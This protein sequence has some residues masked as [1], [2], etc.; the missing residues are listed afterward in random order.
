[1]YP[2]ATAP[3]L[4]ADIPAVRMQPPLSRG[5]STHRGLLILAGVGAIVVTGFLA[6][7][8]IASASL[9]VLFAG[10]KYLSREPGPPIIA[11]AFSYQW[12][13][14]TVGIFYFALTGRRV[15]EMQTDDYR[16]MVWIGLASV[17]VLFTGFYIA[18]RF[19]RIRR[20]RHS[21][22]IL[23]PWTTYR[24]AVTYGITVAI[25]GA[26]QE[27][28]WTMSGLTQVILVFSRVRYVFLFFLITRLSKPRVRI[29]LITAIVL[30][31]VVLG[32]T[33]F[34]ADFREPLVII[35]VAMFGTMDR[36]KA[37]SWLIVGS[38]AL[39]ALGSALIWT[40]VKSIVRQ[41]YI[42]SVSASQRLNTI[43][44]VTGSTLTL[45]AEKWKGET[46]HLVSR[47]WSV[48]FAGLAYKR[49]PDVIPF[50]D[51]AILRGAIENVVVPRL[52]FPE[53]AVLP[54]SSDEVRK[55]SGVWVE[56]RETNTSFAF[57]Y[58]GE[59]FVDFGLPFMFLPIFILG[60]VL[61]FGYYWLNTRIVFDE[62][63]VGVTIVIF[64]ATMGLYESSWVMII[65]PSITIFTVLGGGSVLLDKV[66]RSSTR[67]SGLRSR[68][69]PAR[70]Y[71][72]NA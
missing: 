2:L 50:E 23:L 40:S 24:I 19:R 35:G 69:P 47:I 46:D 17:I 6:D 57:G 3:G 34:F 60:L 28:A 61:G 42:E 55:Y 38:I 14:V 54:S 59:S 41:Q 31:E 4:A 7:D 25:S 71:A 49:V 26:L 33:G 45:G 5:R 30:T 9:I 11:A 29:P 21:V 52:F 39:L 18:G 67:K 1:M 70:T 43:A 51:G 48:Y 12:L 22:P 20:M 27:T 65:G 44:T 62:L 64:W 53:K 32:F 8:W 13:Q 63:R 68:T 10:W 36:K 16:P 37:G 66:L 58:V 72:T 56:G 15:I